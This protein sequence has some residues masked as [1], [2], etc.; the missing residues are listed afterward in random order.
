L[1][2]RGVNALAESV[3][4][5]YMAEVIHRRGT[6]RGFDHVDHATLE[7]ARHDGPDTRFRRRT[8]WVIHSDS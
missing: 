1:T 4:G 3:L 8:A 7:S 6:W 2:Q 5:L